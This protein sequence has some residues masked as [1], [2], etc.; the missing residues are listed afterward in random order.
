[1]V[2]EEQAFMVEELL[3][4]VDLERKT[5]QL[6]LLMVVVDLELVEQQLAA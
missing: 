4:L 2:K 6:V 5:V 1:V 3:D